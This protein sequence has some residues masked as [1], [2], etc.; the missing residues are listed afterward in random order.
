MTKSMLKWAEEYLAYRRKLGF[1]LKTEGRLILNFARHANAIGQRGPLTTDLALN[2]ACLPD[3]ST[4]L[5]HARRLEVVRC[6]A[7]YLAI[8]DHRTQIPNGHLLGR[9]HRRTQPHIYSPAEIEGLLRAA[10]ALSPVDGL[11]PRTYA[12]LIGLMASTGLRTQEALRLQRK[13]VDLGAGI[14]SVRETKFHKSRLVPLDGTVAHALREY[15]RFRD[16]YIACPSSSTFLLGEAGR[17]LGYSTVYWTFRR[18]RRACAIHTVTSQRNPRLYD[19]RHTFCTRRLLVWHRQGID[20]EHAI[21]ALSTYVGHIKVTDTYWYLS[22]IP[23][24]FAVTGAKF[25]QYAHQ[26]EGEQ[27]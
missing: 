13:D 27:R 22:G 2:W 23:E 12:T 24:L 21:A 9:A 4:R 6:F 26:R 11:R 8:F 14:L 15:A 17:Q 5:Y 25:E 10:R 20:V 16:G 19:L 3:H 18:L 1:K 7:K